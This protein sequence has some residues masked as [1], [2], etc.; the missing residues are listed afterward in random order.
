MMRLI[1][2]FPF[3]FRPTSSADDDI[4]KE[5]KKCTQTV[6]N[7]LMEHTAYI[8]ACADQKEL[9]LKKYKDQVRSE[10]TAEEEPKEKDGMYM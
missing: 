2:L 3:L 5:I 1:Y 9:D 10:M 8:R 6:Q 7:N 4:L